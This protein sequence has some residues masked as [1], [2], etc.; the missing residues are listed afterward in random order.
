[1]KNK[2]KE[3]GEFM[4]IW[5]DLNEDGS[6]DLINPKSLMSMTFEKAVGSLRW[7]KKILTKKKICFIYDP[8]EVSL[9]NE[10]GSQ[11]LELI[12]DLIDQSEVHIKKEM[13]G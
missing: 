11:D 8:S 5:A 10:D 13:K 1:M 12:K 7:T 2:I 6:Y 3:D 4:L 9:F